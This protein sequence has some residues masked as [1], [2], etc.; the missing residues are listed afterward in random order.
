MKYAARI[1]AENKPSPTNRILR[2][3][4][5]I[6]ARPARPAQ[7]VAAI[8]LGSNSFHMLVARSVNGDVHVLDRLQEMVRL[9]GGLDRRGYLDKHAR[10]RSLECLRRFGERLRGIPRGSVRAV[11]TDTLR[12]ARNSKKFLFA[13]ERA[14]GHSIEIISGQEEARLIYQGVAHDLPDDGKSR[15]IVD[16]GGGSTE[17]IIGQCFDTRLA[18][19]LHMGCVGFSLRHFRR[20]RITP[21][22]WRK[23]VTAAQ[24]E[25]QPIESVFRA[26]GW[27]TAYGTSGTIR[28]VGAVLRAQGWSGGEI[29]LPALR[30]L[31]DALFAAARVERLR[32]EGLNPDR[33]AIFPAGVAILTAIFES[34]GIERMEVSGGALREGLLYDLLG[35][36]RHVDARDRTI[37][38]LTERYHIDPAQAE[39]V[40]QTAAH[41]L[42]QLAE[43]WELDERDRQA[44]S[45]AAQLHEIGLA[46]AHTKYHRHG[47]YLVANADMPGFSWQEQRLLATLIRAHRRG[48]PTEVFEVL[49]K[50]ERRSARRLAIILRLAVLLHRGRVESAP[51]PI[52]L[53]A[54]RRRL[55]IRFPRGWLKRNPLTHADLVREVEYVTAGKF[56]LK[57]D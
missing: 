20:A 39:R 26:E 34:L 11:G 48:F 14:L 43:S 1:S 17:F 31:N 9:A 53:T 52:R 23:A 30:K 42:A 54:K 51:P 16:I 10:A 49:P 44:L 55:A 50:R 8:D 36:M 13:A 15:L 28:A 18:E 6:V 57:I 25:L 56:V 29:T 21:R 40:R 27:Q 19:S 5:A 45:W 47:A 12:R 4:R 3:L 35:R 38:A 37:A 24:L 32:F 7:T 46:I 33:A 41:C 2:P 22:A